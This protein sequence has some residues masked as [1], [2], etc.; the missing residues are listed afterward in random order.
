[1]NSMN[2]VDSPGGCPS[3]HPPPLPEGESLRSRAVLAWSLGVALLAGVL[4]APVRAATPADVVRQSIPLQR[5]WNAVHLKVDPLDPLPAAVFRGLPV[6]KVATFFP[7]RTP[8]EFIQDPGSANWKQEGWSVWFADTVP[9]AALSDLFSIPGGQGYLIY[10]TAPATWEI[11]G[12]VGVRPVRWRADSYNLVGFAVDPVSPPTFA[13]WFAGSPAHQPGKRPVIYR[14]DG[15]GHWVPVDRRD[16]TLIEPNAA[17]W[18]FCQ[19]GSDY[20]GPLEVSV[21]RGVPGL[22]LEYGSEAETITLQFRNRTASPVRFDVEMTPAGAV[23]L[24]YERRVTQS[25]D[26][27]REPLDGSSSFGPLEAGEDLVLRVTLDRSALPGAV[28]ALLTVRD[29]IGGRV[30]IPVSGRLP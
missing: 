9:E 20:Q 15:S 17:Y 22:G 16:A 29:D 10:A 19:G 6:E 25:N 1:M 4:T 12:R 27:V 18:V 14:L 30:Q 13:Q 7:R 23:P 2:T 8:V 11:E 28:A 26:R 5:G 21:P 24:S 3:Q